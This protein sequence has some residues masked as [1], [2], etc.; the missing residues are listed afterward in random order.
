MHSTISFLIARNG[1]HPK[2]RRRKK[3]EGKPSSA[4]NNMHAWTVLLHDEIVQGNYFFCFLRWL[5]GL[6]DRQLRF[7]PV[8]AD[9]EIRAAAAEELEM[10]EA[11]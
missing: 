7:K 8:R 1:Q 11:M 9:D 5:T 3:G 2:E 10:Q 6:S 4:E